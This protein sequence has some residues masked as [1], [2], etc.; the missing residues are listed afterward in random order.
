METPKTP[1]QHK[2]ELKTR[3]HTVLLRLP[4]Y[5]INTF[6]HAYP[7]YK[8]QRKHIYNVACGRSLDENVIHRFE[9]FADLI[10]PKTENA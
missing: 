6:L 10:A 2:E 5:F 7:E 9:D 4:A 1:K 3:L 8:E